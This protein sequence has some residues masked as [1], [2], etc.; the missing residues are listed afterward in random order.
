[1]VGS[2]MRLK[3]L[4]SGLLP[5]PLRPMIPTTSP[6]FDVQAH[7]FEVPKLFDFIALHDLTTSREIDCLA[8]EIA[9]LT[10]NN[11]SKSGMFVFS[12][13]AR[14]MAEANNFLTDS[15]RQ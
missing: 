7:I 1:V 8:C 2:V 14:S 6:C 15:R 10:P 3:I 11:F 12:I 5:A 4:S 9:Y 13:R